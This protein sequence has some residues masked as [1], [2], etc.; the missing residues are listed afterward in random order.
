MNKKLLAKINRKLYTVE[1]VRRMYGDQIKYYRK[2]NGLSQQALGDRLGVSATAVHKWERGMS[3][4]DIVALKK[5]ADMFGVSIDQL[6]DH[7]ACTD[8]N[9]PEEGNIAVMTR[10]FRRLS[11][12]EQ[13]KLIAVGKAL[14]EHAFGREEKP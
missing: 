11:A 2:K 12:Q 10:A 9:E 7:Q 5:M 3:Q 13:E 6:C 1:E 4:P 8:E 14:F